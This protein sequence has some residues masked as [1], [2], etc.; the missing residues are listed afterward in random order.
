M[1]LKV[2]E[3]GFAMF[4]CPGCEENHRIRVKTPADGQP[5]P[6]WAHIPMWGWNGSAER[7]SFAPS[8]HFRGKCHS[9]VEAGKIG[10]LLDSAHKLAGQTVEI[11]E[12]ESA[13]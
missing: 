1:K 3:N 6:E 5:H 11:P 9:F 7:P 2:S 4:R 12:W 10:F 8:L 13:E